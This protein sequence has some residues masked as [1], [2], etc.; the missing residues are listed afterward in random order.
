MADQFN[1]DVFLSHSNKDKAIV[2]ELAERLRADG[3]R[4]WLDEWILKPT[5][6]KATPSP[7]SQIDGSRNILMFRQ[8]QTTV[9][10]LIP[11]NPPF[12]LPRFI[13]QTSSSSA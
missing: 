10:R 7:A 6:S 9:L 5:A 13:G 12:D 8:K 11:C 2:R 4:V 3:L 1:Y